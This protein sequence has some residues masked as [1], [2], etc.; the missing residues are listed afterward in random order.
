MERVLW[1]NGWEY[2]KQCERFCTNKVTPGSALMHVTL[3]FIA[4]LKD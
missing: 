2:I 4:A 1:G 3:D